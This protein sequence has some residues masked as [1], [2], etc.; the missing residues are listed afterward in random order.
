VITRIQL[1][2]KVILEND[3]NGAIVQLKDPVA[4]GRTIHC[5]IQMKWCMQYLNHEKMAISGGNTIAF[6]SS[7]ELHMGM[8]RDRKK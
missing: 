3:N 7:D 2:V 4:K 5:D 6:R 1:L 8:T